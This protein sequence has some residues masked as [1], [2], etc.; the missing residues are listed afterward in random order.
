M[1]NSG[2][3]Q[4]RGHFVDPAFR[5]MRF[6]LDDDFCESRIFGRC[7]PT[8]W[9]NSFFLFIEILIFRKRLG[10]ATYF[11]FIFFKKKNQIRNKTLSVTPEGKTGL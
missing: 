9:R 8:R 7:V 6:P 3:S 1:I 2:G 5:L 4:W 10:V 11:C